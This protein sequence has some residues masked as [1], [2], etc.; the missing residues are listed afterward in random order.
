MVNIEEV[1]QAR[2]RIQNIIHNTP[3]M[4]S[5]SLQEKWGRQVFF[6]AEHLQKKLV[7]K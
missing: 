4:H 3:I 5:R 1:E 2:S 6:K 7:Q